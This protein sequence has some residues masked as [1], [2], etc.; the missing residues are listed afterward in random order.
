MKVLKVIG[1]LNRV[2]L[3]T[4]ED[5]DDDDELYPNGSTIQ[6]YYEQLSSEQT[7][8]TWSRSDGKREKTI[9][10]GDI[11]NVFSEDLLTVLGCKQPKWDKIHVNCEEEIFL[12]T[13]SITKYLEMQANRFPHPDCLERIFGDCYLIDMDTDEIRCCQRLRKT[14]HTFRN[15]IDDT[16]PKQSM[17]VLEVDGCPDRIHLKT[18]RNDD[19]ELYP[20]GPKV[21][22][23]Y[24][25]FEKRHT[26]IT[27]NRS[28]EK[29]EKL[30]FNENGLELFYRD[31]GTI[32][33]SKVSKW[34]MIVLMPHIFL[35][36][37]SVTKT[38][39]LDGIH[40]PN[41][42][43]LKRIFGEYLYLVENEDQISKVW[44]FKRP[45]NYVVCM[46]FSETYYGYD[47]FIIPAGD[48]P[49]EALIH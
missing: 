1:S 45:D 34:D 40:F 41:P 24:E 11:L 3:I 38:L 5:D 28:D 17:N 30:I 19:K 33:E 6:L 32:L 15:F 49:Q 14:C 8:I 2:C 21:D 20:N 48:V 36:T 43:Y 46:K 7:I 23:L 27:W 4:C 18:Y 31:F 35:N 12:N 47:I 29:R 44:Y 13:L 37:P 25:E 39:E 16:K 10:K 42:E 9:N 22:L 26:K